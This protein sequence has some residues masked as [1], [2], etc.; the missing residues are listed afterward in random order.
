MCM[1]IDVFC[2][3]RDHRATSNSSAGMKKATSSFFAGLAVESYAFCSG[4]WSLRSTLNACKDFH[5]S[6]SLGMGAELGSNTHEWQGR[7]L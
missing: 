2:S 4:R 5:Q 6:N 7:S 3:H 1:T